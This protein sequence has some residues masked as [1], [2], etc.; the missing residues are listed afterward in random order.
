MPL[1]AEGLT[2]ED[3]KTV[4][5]LLLKC[6]AT[7]EE[8][9][10]VRKHLSKIKGGR[11][12]LMIHPAEMVNLIVIDE[13][14]GKP[15]G[16]TISDETTFEDAAAVLNKYNLWDIIPENVRIHLENADQ[17]S[18]T[19][20]EGEFEALC[21]KAS[22]FIL[23]NN[24]DACEA[25]AEEAERLGYNASILTT[26]LEGES[27]DVG[28]ALSA[29]AR[30]VESECRPIKS[31]CVIVSGGETT[32]TL[33]GEVGEGGRNQELALSASLKIAG[34]EHIVLASLGT[35]GTDGPTDL[36]GAIVDGYTVSRAQQMGID[37]VSELKNHN[38]SYVFRKLGD[39]LYTGP[40]ATNVMDLQ[41][42]VVTK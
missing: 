6:G 18:E 41:V 21:V 31:P 12:A 30:E 36:A 15:W 19:P 22:T 27:K 11:L 24:A 29:V 3:K 7:I 25:A 9:N 16:P 20:K 2:L 1:P 38:S 26:S 10:T 35:D 32:V 37:L 5:R 33:V 17:K 8:I 34:S 40:T 4:N 39:A 42:I 13:V 23:A 14:A 28:I